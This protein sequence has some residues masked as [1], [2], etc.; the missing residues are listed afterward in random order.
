MVGTLG[1]LGRLVGYCVLLAGL[2]G[3]YQNIKRGTLEQT[4]NVVAV[5]GTTLGGLLLAQYAPALAAGIAGLFSKFKTKT[6]ESRL[7]KLAAKF[8]D[9][10][11][12]Y[13]IAQTDRRDQEAVYHLASRA[14][15][16][17]DPK[18]RKQMLDLCRDVNDELFNMHHAVEGTTPDAPT[19]AK[20]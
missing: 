16:I 10:A 18:R 8:M 3:G 2:V 7:A 4:P 9:G 6:G 5:G 19:P 12:K 14:A 20:T 11:G 1:F 13:A 17:T 15:Q